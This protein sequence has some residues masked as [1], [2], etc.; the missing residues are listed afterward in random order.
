MEDTKFV[1]IDDNNDHPKIIDKIEKL[2]NNIQNG[3]HI[4]LFLSMDGCGHCISTKPN[5][6]NIKYKLKTN[7]NN[8]VVARINS[9][10]FDKV[11]GIGS[12]PSGFPTLRYIK[13]DKVKEYEDDGFRDRST[14]SFV[15]WIKNKVNEKKGGS[16]K[17]KSRKTSSR[18]GG[19][20][21]SRKGG[22]KTRKSKK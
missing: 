20:K 6:D 2:N 21:A 22:K 5:W 4:F 17:R 15:E 18:K 13:G 10:L 8:Y 16:K 14:D 3:K 1:I 19:K 7:N 11:K 9:N 12:E